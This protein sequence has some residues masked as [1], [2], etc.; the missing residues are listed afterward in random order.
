[1]SSS[2]Y[3]EA[4]EG[5]GWVVFASILLTL[6]GIWNFFD[7]ILAITS[8]H[9]Y[10]G[11]THFVFSDLKTWGWIVM[12]LGV[13]QLMAAAALVRGSDVAKWFAIFIA[14]VNALGQ[15]G[16]VSAN[17]FWSLSMFVIDLLIIYGLA[18]YGGAKLKMM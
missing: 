5:V 3:S 10:V 17:P 8:S 2:S 7:G 14:V 6:A 4:P 16:F 11:A 12:I 9:V 15:L 13:L 18:V 1:M